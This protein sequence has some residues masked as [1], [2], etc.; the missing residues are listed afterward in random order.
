MKLRDYRIDNFKLLLTFLVI[1]GH[2]LHQITSY[3]NY[4]TMYVI[5][6]IYLFHMPAFTIISGYFSKRYSFKKAVTGFLIPYIIIQFFYAL[7]TNEIIQ[8]SLFLKPLFGLWYFFALFIWRILPRIKSKIVFFI[9]FLL[10]PYFATFYTEDSNY[11][12]SIGRII[13]FYPYFLLGYN[14]NFLTSNTLSKLNSILLIIIP[15]VVVLLAVIYRDRN[16]L[17]IEYLSNNNSIL[18]IS[19]LNFYILYFVQ[20]ITTLS[21]IKGLL[22]LVSKKNSF[23]T[24]F[25]KYGIHYYYAHIFLMIP[26]MGL[27]NKITINNELLISLFIS[28][29]IFLLL[30]ILFLSLTY[31]KK[32]II[33]KRLI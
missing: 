13:L 2:V 10:V 23:I 19:L 32:L 25:S 16:L 17:D 20:F 15:S 6:L 12:L 4:D 29:I 9:I 30:S 28:V 7:L 24:S 22:G 1:Y 11:I 21:I 3:L 26:L 5:S 14:F 33:K 8:L 18:N 27:K 31:V